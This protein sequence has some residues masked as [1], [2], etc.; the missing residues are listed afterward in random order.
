MPIKDIKEKIIRDALE[1]KEK[2]IRDAEIKIENLKKQHKREN[3]SIRQDIMER[4][5]QEAN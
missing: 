1:E 5:M 3:E 4:Y 2:I